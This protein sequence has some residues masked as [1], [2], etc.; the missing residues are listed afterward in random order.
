M[1]QRISKKIEKFKIW[2]K[3]KKEAKKTQGGK[4]KQTKK[5]KKK[6]KKNKKKKKKKKEKK[7]KNRA[8]GLDTTQSWFINSKREKG[9]DSFFQ[10]P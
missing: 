9:G 2:G 3:K 1:N 10:K 7:K 4:K 5:T 8:K 6:K